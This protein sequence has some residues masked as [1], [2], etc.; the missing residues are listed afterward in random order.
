MALLRTQLG[1]IARVAPADDEAR[2]VIANEAVKD[3]KVMALG[4]L[5]GFVLAFAK[6]K[7]QRKPLGQALR[8]GRAAL[9]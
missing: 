8:E 2:E 1:Y 9:E 5:G 3:A 4:A 6:A 7:F